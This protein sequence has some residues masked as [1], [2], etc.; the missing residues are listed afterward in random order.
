MVKS[1]FDTAYGKAFFPGTPKKRQRFSLSA[2]RKRLALSLQF[3]QNC[4]RWL[5]YAMQILRRI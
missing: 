1:L 2:K 4:Y 5:H 3:V